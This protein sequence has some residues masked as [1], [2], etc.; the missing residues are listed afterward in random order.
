MDNS[1]SVVPY[2]IFDQD[3]RTDPVVQPLYAGAV[4]VRSAEVFFQ[5]VA[6]RRT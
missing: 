1:L 3:L 4:T 2:G 5:A 6:A